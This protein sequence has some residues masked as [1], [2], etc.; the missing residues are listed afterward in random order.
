[1]VAQGYGDGCAHQTIWA[2][3]EDG[4]DDDVDDDLV[5]VYFAV[6]LFEKY[7]G[8]CASHELEDEED[9]FELPIDDPAKDAADEDADGPHE[10][11]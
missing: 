6:K 4:T 1:M 5:L 2:S 8:D 9:L 11:D 7:E 3:V 10:S